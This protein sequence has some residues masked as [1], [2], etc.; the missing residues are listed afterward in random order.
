MPAHVIY[1]EVDAHPAGFSARWLR[2]ILRLELGFDGAIFSDDLSMA[3]ARRVGDAEVSYAEAAALALAAGCD[4][5]LL[6][7]QSLDGGAAVDTLLDELLVAEAAGHWQADPDSETRRRDLLP[8][9][10]P[11]VWDELMHQPAYQRSL[12]RLP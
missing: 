6:C 2:E 12:E 7:N 5:V 9:T 8:Q 10:A 4:M 11:V 1:P 3:G